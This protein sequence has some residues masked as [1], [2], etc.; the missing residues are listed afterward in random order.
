MSVQRAL[1]QE[2]AKAKEKEQQ[3]LMKSE[4]MQKNKLT[5]NRQKY[6]EVDINTDQN[7]IL[8][9][10]SKNIKCSIL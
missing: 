6:M 1:E 9:Q 4:R 10:N 3:Q 7:V 5:L 2:M 8:T